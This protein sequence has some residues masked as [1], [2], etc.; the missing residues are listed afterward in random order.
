MWQEVWTSGTEDRLFELNNGDIPGL[1]GVVVDQCF[2][3]NPYEHAYM[4]ELEVYPG[5][6]QPPQIWIPIK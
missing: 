1:L 6:N 5:P 2:P 3:S 4:P